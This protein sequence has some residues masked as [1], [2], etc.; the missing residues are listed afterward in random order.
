MKVCGKTVHDVWGLMG[1][2]RVKWPH[3]ALSSGAQFKCAL[4]K[5]LWYIK[6]ILTFPTFHY[7]IHF[8]FSKKNILNHSLFISHY[9]LFI[10]I[11]IKNHYKTKFYHFPIPLFHFPISIIFF[12]FFFKGE[13]RRGVNSAVGGFH[14]V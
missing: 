14:V 12:F 2:A 5:Q 13:Q 9:L 4:I 10:T 11:Q 6:C 8:I 3:E 7:T 1:I